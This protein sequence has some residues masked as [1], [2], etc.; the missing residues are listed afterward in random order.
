M[1]YVC[2]DQEKVYYGINEENCGGCR[3]KEDYVKT[4]IEGT[5]KL[6]MYLCANYIQHLW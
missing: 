5:R 1:L 3:S 6:G 4:I 2:T